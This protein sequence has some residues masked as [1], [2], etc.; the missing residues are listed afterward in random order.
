MVVAAV[1]EV[2]KGEAV[3]TQEAV[4]IPAAAG[5]QIKE[6]LVKAISL[7]AAVLAAPD[8]NW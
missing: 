8:R 1:E 4:A 7:A 6:V 2:A 3:A 5:E